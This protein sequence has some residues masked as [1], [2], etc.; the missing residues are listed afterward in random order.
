MSLDARKG[1]LIS[2]VGSLNSDLTVLST[3]TLNTNPRDPFGY[4][5]KNS[6]R[7]YNHEKYYS[8][9]LCCYPSLVG[10][11]VNIDIWFSILFATL[12]SSHLQPKG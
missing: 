3:N 2:T 5:F 4:D 1:L 7:G 11:Y 6:F 12:H 8:G 10:M 9:S